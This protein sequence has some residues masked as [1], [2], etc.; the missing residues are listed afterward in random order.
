MIIFESAH[1]FSVV[2]LDVG[3]QKWKQNKNAVFMA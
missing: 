3:F 2:S 1:L